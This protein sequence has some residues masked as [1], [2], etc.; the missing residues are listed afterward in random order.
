MVIKDEVLQNDYKKL[1]HGVRLLEKTKDS[2]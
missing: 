2:C 1:T